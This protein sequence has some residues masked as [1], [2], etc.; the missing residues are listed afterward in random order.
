ML[1]IFK[2]EVAESTP[3]S[4]FFRNASAKEKK[5]VFSEVSKKASEDQLKLI[6]Q[7]GKQN[8]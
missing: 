5:R 6:K 1:G 3:L 2:E 4:D 7:A 8:R